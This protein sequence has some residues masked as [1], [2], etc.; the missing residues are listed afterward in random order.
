MSSNSSVYSSGVK[1]KSLLWTFEILRIVDG[2]K[3]FS[4]AVTELSVVDLSS[5]TAF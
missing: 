1:T 5:V 4:E 3:V 2:V